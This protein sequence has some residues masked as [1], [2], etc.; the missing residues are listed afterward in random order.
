LRR[1][2]S[3]LY[4]VEAVFGQRP[5]RGLWFGINAAYQLVG[6]VIAAVVVTVQS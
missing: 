3:T 4:A 6:I 5:W 2:N 1:S